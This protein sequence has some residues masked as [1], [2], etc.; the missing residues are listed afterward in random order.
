MLNYMGLHNI[1]R[2]RHTCSSVLCKQWHFCSDCCHKHRQSQ[3]SLRIV[4]INI[5]RLI[6]VFTVRLNLL[7]SEMKKKSD[8]STAS[9]ERVTKRSDSSSSSLTKKLKSK[10]ESWKRGWYWCP[11]VLVLNNIFVMMFYLVTDPL[12]SVATKRKS[13]H[14]NILHYIYQNTLGQRLH[15]QMRRVM[16]LYTWLRH[17][18]ISIY[19]YLKSLIQI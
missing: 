11:S 8:R 1:E 18:K 16:D 2:C 5:Y 6:Y 10:K 12:K 4:C 17:F 14:G 3:V 13:D 19:F 15:S 7:V 9:T